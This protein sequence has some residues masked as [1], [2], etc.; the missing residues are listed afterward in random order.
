MTFRLFNT[1]ANTEDESLVFVEDFVDGI[2]MQ[3]WRIYE[4][5]PVAAHYPENAKI[6]LRPENR[7]AKLTWYVGNTR[8]MLLVAE[9]FKNIIESVCAGVEIEY[10]PVTI[11][12]QRKRP[13]GR[14]YFIVNPIGTFDCLDLQKSDIE[15]DSDE[16][17]ELIRLNEPVLDRKKTQDAPE[18]FRIKEDSRRYVVGPRLVQAME[19]QAQHFE[20]ILW[21]NL[22]FG[23]EL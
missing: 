17:K 2:N 3:S 13:Y 22:S 1:L 21:Q 5:K 8:S 7:G 19:Q 14:S 4:G 23:D 9:G 20:N 18:L 6:F 16:P 11:H 12:D 15:W 10:L